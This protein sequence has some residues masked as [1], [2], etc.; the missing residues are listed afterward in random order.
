MAC[1]FA[2]FRYAAALPGGTYC[3]TMDPNHK[4]VYERQRGLALAIILSGTGV[5][6]FDRFRLAAWC[7]GTLD[8]W[9]AGFFCCWR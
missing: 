7:M 9:Q 4:P 5:A 3:I 2:F 8:G 1:N 6:A